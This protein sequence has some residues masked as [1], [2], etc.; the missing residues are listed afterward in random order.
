M[1]VPYVLTNSVPELA[2]T[3]ADLDIAHALLKEWDV[4]GGLSTC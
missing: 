3:S 2:W 4:R 1:P